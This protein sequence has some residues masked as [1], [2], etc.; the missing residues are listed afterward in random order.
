MR[1]PRWGF[2]MIRRILTPQISSPFFDHFRLFFAFCENP[3]GEAPLTWFAGHNPLAKHSV[4]LPSQ[5][6]GRLEP[7][8]MTSLLSTI[9]YF[10]LGRNANIE[11]NSQRKNTPSIF[12]KKY[13][14]FFPNLFI[15]LPLNENYYKTIFAIFSRFDFRG[16]IYFSF[17]A[18]GKSARF[19]RFYLFFFRSANQTKTLPCLE[20]KLYTNA[21]NRLWWRLET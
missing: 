10:A 4:A 2:R 16:S 7:S 19:P 3:S 8:P 14:T 1:S 15:F 21:M 13:G 12:A 11:Q 9:L 20:L 18:A 6:N 17:V 5:N